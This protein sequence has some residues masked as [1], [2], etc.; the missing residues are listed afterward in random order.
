MEVIMSGF[1]IKTKRLN[2]HSFDVYY[3]KYS[4]TSY[5]PEH[6]PQ[7]CAWN[8]ATQEDWTIFDKHY[9]FT[10]PF[11]FHYNQKMYYGLLCVKSKMHKMKDFISL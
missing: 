6:S 7:K 4:V 11:N 10:K 3:V 1:E 9:C 2:W 8:L 5:R